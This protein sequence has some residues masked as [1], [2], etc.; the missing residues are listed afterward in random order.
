[1]PLASKSFRALCGRRGAAAAA[2]SRRGFALLVTILLV[3]LLV[4][5]LVGLAT[6]ARVETQAAENAQ[7]L[8][9]ARQ[10]ALFAMNVALGEL[11]RTAGPDQRAT[12]TADIGTGDDGNLATDEDGDPT[13]PDNGLPVAGDGTYPW[14][15]VL[16]NRANPINPL[17]VRRAAHTAEN[18][19]LLNWL[20][21]GNEAA[22]V[23]AFT[24]DSNVAA[25]NDFGFGQIARAPGYAHPAST[26][27]TTPAALLF[28]PSTPITG[29]TPTSVVSNTLPGGGTNPA[30]WPL[31]IGTGGSERPAVLLVGPGSA[32]NSVDPA[33]PQAN[34]VVAPVVD[35][36]VPSAEVPGSGTGAG[37]VTVGRY[38]W[39]VGDE[40]VKARVD[41]DDEDFGAS[42][43][44]NENLHQLLVPARPAAWRV[45]GLDDVAEVASPM[46]N[47]VAHEQLAFVAGISSAEAKA[48]FHDI[49]VHSRS[50]LAN[51]ASG[52][53][54]KDLTAGFRA[55][56]GTAGQVEIDDS[57]PLFTLP[58]QPGDT[59][60]ANGSVTVATDATNLRTPGWSGRAPSADGLP[61]WGALRN[62]SR[63]TADAAGA[64]PAVDVVRGSNTAP[65]RLPVLVR[66]QVLVYGAV[67]GSSAHAIYMPSAVLWNP[68]DV[69]LRAGQRYAVR[70]SINFNDFNNDD[71]GS[72]KTYPG[73][74]RSVAFAFVHSN[75][76]ADDPLTTANESALG[77]VVYR[78][79]L[80][81]DRAYS[82]RVTA[83]T[84]F[85]FVLDCTEDIEPGQAMVFTPE[86]IS[87]LSANPSDRVLKP[88]NRTGAVYPTYFHEPLGYNVPAGRQL[89]Y[90]YWSIPSLNRA[91]RLDFGLGDTFSTTG[92]PANHMPTDLVFTLPW[93][94]TSGGLTGGRAGDPDVAFR[95]NQSAPPNNDPTNAITGLETAPGAGG[96]PLVNSSSWGIR[97]DSFSVGGGALTNDNGTPKPP[98]A[99]PVAS[100]L[101][102]PVDLALGSPVGPFYRLHYGRAFR[103]T[104]ANDDGNGARPSAFVRWVA[105]YNPVFPAMLTDTVSLWDD[106]LGGSQTVAMNPPLAPLTETFHSGNET[107]K[108]N[109]VASANDLNSTYVGITHHLITP[110]PP[111]RLV[112]LHV[113]RAETGVLSIGALQHAQVHPVDTMRAFG[114][115]PMPA[116]L[117]DTYSPTAMPLYPVGNAMADPR[118]HP[119]DVDGFPNNWNSNTLTS[120]YFNDPG[121]SEDERTRPDRRR[122]HFDAS[123]VLNR[124]LW[125]RYFFS[126]INAGAKTSRNPRYS[127]YDPNGL[128]AADEATELGRLRSFGGAAA[129]LLVDGG[130]NANS[131]S[132]EAWRAVLSST[133]KIAVERLDGAAADVAPGADP[134]TPWPRFPRPGAHAYGRPDDLSSGSANRDS[135]AHMFRSLTDGQINTLATEI[136]REI[137]RRG[138]ALTLSGFVNRKPQ[139]GAAPS[140]GNYMEDPSDFPDVASQNQRWQ[141]LLGTLQLAI[142]RAGLN[143]HFDYVAD[144]GLAGVG[145]DG[146]AQVAFSR[147]FFRQSA[148]G[149]KDHPSAVTVIPSGGNEIPGAPVSLRTTAAAMPSFL[150][151]ADILQALGS[152]L[153]TRSD[154]FRIRTYG[155]VINPAT[156][157]VSA[158][159]WAE[160]IV[161]RLPDFVDSSQQPEL[162]RSGSGAQPW[163]T[164]EAPALG[165]GMAINP[166]NRTFGRRFVVVGFR[167]LDASDI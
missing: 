120:S 107:R 137:R 44:S 63:W 68:Y 149:Q 50:V 59:A 109:V 24:S 20:V 165:A 81:L 34:Y 108:R 49:T 164:D 92:S 1:M 4:L 157:E 87:E 146:H 48:R 123:L 97:G 46:D 144:L 161:Q 38:A 117:S 30:A 118:V 22:D 16:G 156:Q 33:N 133:R 105:N 35:I 128:V 145:N 69:T 96:F 37:N 23:V 25:P 111:S 56:S 98:S 132:E 143:A 153:S 39:W 17:D 142:D 60:V 84:G 74:R 43:G 70:I 106:P 32:G 53:L 90:V 139:A 101:S 89:D 78:N 122:L 76:P 2:V 26:P 116:S 57:N 52:G 11:Q 66:A 58:V 102:A 163:L 64:N 140:A 27:A 62:Y 73:G 80:Q 126:G 154:T 141:R 67:T 112:M 103:G 113:P 40:G 6:F 19:I 12:V 45:D 86:A 31:R 155:D 15:G 167:W 10:N 95:I 61:M 150:T 158:R 79:T 152:T 99:W 100:S 9:K 5:I 134:F 18:P 94:E 125:D 3:A 85:A 13:T 36:A 135:H 55:N 129:R 51:T 162:W 42:A 47:L 28:T 41:L 127:V 138:P 110:E 77:N 82:S 93:L 131:T 8:A 136:V 71:W 124:A 75:P 121:P 119:S 7:N 148:A 114:R 14:T 115:V 151:Q 130:F 91:Q 88:G 21:S 104:D 83:D 29:L 166:T 160:V 147:L 159:A 72:N 65:S 54:K